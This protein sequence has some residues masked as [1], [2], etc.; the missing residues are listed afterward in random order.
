[1]ALLKVNSIDVAIIVKVLI[2]ETMYKI[3]SVEKGTNDYFITKGIYEL[4][5][6]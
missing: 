4:V 5:H 2:E 3:I 1:M 6:P